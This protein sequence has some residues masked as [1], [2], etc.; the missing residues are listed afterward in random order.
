MVAVATLSWGRRI[1]YLV[2]DHMQPQGCRV[3]LSLAT[4]ILTGDTDSSECWWIAIWL[5]DA[6]GSYSSLR[7]HGWV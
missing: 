6:S 1:R 5:V 3:W 7:V 4:N 2:W